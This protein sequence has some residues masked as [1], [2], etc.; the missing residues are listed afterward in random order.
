LLQREAE[1]GVVFGFVERLPEC[2]PEFSDRLV[3]L[4]L[5][6]QSDAEVVV[7]LGEVGPE[8]DRRAVFTD[9]HRSAGTLQGLD[10]S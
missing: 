4:L 5:H 1:V 8:P 2:R 7:E 3:Q 9:R 6:C 10:R